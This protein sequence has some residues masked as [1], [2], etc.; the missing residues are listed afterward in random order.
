MAKITVHTGVTDKTL[1][2]APPAQLPPSGPED[3]PPEEE[4]EGFVWPTPSAVKDE[5][6]VALARY[7][8]NIDW[9]ADPV[10]T[11]RPLTKDQIQ[12]LAH[13][14]SAGDVVLDG[15]GVPA[16]PADS[17]ELQPASS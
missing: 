14:L 9:A 4:V 17:A 13:A 6:V 3:N 10:G 2:P 11:G 5:W 16:D 7:G 8:V 1:E 15:N 12:A